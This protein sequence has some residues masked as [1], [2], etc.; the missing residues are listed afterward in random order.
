[1][2][3]RLARLKKEMM[4][5]DVALSMPCWLSQ[6]NFSE[7]KQPT[8]QRQSNVRTKKKSIEP[9]LLHFGFIVLI[10]LILIYVSTG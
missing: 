8:G 7:V 4:H 6:F 9:I 5:S 2:K 1:M 3:I 10:V